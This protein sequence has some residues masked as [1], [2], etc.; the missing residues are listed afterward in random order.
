MTA[1]SIFFMVRNHLR[2]SIVSVDCGHGRRIVKLNARVEHEK[3]Q[4]VLKPGVPM[5][6]TD[7]IGA[8]E[9]WV[10]SRGA[11]A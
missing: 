5:N 6:T 4:D 3:R 7:R 1:N 9:T 10:S 8:S 11:T 2:L